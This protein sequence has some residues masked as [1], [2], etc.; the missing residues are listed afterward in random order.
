MKMKTN[1]AAA[2]RMRFTGNG[3]KVKRK[4]AFGRHIMRAK[5][6]KQKRHMKT[7]HYIHSANIAN[8]DRLLPNG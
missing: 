7:T 8:V 2:K 5:N 1:K 3:K 4:G 6:A